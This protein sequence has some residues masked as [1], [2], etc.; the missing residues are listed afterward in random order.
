MTRRAT[1]QAVDLGEDAVFAGEGEA[2]GVLAAADLDAPGVRARDALAF[3]GVHDAVVLDVEVRRAA[4]AP[5]AGGLPGVGTCAR[6]EDERAE[7]REQRLFDGGA[8]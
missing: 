1:G 2:D 6:A 7:R 8:R 3:D 5:G 4:G